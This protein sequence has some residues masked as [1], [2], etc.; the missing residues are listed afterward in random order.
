MASALLAEWAI[1]L[2]AV[3][4]IVTAVGIIWKKVAVPLYQKVRAAETV[5]RRVILAADRLL[6][7]AEG[8]LKP[9]GGSSLADKI[10]RIEPNHIAAEDHWKRLEDGQQA[11]ARRF[12]EKHGEITTLL[13]SHT[14]RLEAIE[15]KQAG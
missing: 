2:G 3:A 5:V 12:E 7:F 4:A 11:L 9:N 13:Q 6:P 8:Q 14:E 1:H 15:R 10:N